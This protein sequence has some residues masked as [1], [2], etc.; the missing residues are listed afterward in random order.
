MTQV[1]QTWTELG[2]RLE[3]LGLKLKMHLEQSSDGVLPEALAKLGE[4]VKGT[5][6]AAGNAIKDDAV[7]ADVR[8]VGQ[9]LGELVS[10][11]V[12]KVKHG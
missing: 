4:S 6:E 8:E 1:K 2:D 7:K 12:A 3:S 11:A 9:L 10:N 5:F